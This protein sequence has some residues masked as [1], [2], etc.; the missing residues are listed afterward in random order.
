MLTQD[1][2]QQIHFQ[3][4]DNE[5]LLTWAFFHDVSFNV[6][7]RTKDY[8]VKIALNCFEAA[9]VTIGLVNEEIT[10]DFEIDLCEQ[11]NPNSTIALFH[12]VSNSKLCISVDGSEF[13]TEYED[14]RLSS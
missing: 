8:Q 10:D 2:F 3:D 1:H 9:Y 13:Q 4:L 11:A 5:I 14:E 12:D 6:Q 7:N